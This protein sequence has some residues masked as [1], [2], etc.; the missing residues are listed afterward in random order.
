MW[1][2]G[3]QSKHVML[4]LLLL[5]TGILGTA[6]AGGAQ[7]HVTP[8]PTAPAGHMSLTPAPTSASIAYVT[9]FTPLYMKP[10]TYFVAALNTADGSVRWRYTSADLISDM[11]AV[12]DAVLFERH[13]EPS[14][15]PQMNM[16]VALN[17]SD[18][19]VRWT[20]LTAHYSRFTAQGDAVYIGA[21]TNMLSNT[22][23]GSS[24]PGV[25]TSLD[26]RSGA[27]RWRETP[28]VA[29][30]QPVVVD[31][32]LY[33][34]ISSGPTTGIIALDSNTGK[35]Q[36][37]YTD[38]NFLGMPEGE[39][40]GPLVIGNRI[41]TL[42]VFNQ[43]A[44]H[45]L[46]DLVALDAQS[47]SVR[48]RSTI[49]GRVF[50]LATDSN[51]IYLSAELLS[52]SGVLQSP[53]YEVEA[54]RANDGQTLWKTSLTYVPSAP[55]LGDNLVFITA[56]GALTIKSPVDMALALSAADGRALWRI[57][58]KLAFLSHENV[59]TDG[60]LVYVVT[61]RLSAQVSSAT[62]FPANTEVSLIKAIRATDGQPRWETPL[63]V[64]IYP[65]PPVVSDGK[66][67]V[68]FYGGYRPDLAVLDAATGSILWRF[69]AP[70][71]EITRLALPA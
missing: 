22:G 18:G 33:D 40:G 37:L 70:S 32:L 7:R 64:G 21:N 48:W 5:L 11:V 45:P 36:W 47:G 27:I 24:A 44:G 31:S 51:A 6:C 61:Y 41:Y 16:L 59:T 62:P 49:G 14:A 3:S 26:I 58:G 13:A 65:L 35:R 2:T 15:N 71:S 63:G 56:T 9:G 19:S 39:T 42:S 68:A 46:D 34:Y 30:G 55:V 20:Y 67:F 8:T 69:G 23:T 29:V 50:G 52:P 4:A 12:G 57:P 10:T 38:S 54:L 28:A 43:Q 17:A 60:A 66:L 1:H 53:G 25:I